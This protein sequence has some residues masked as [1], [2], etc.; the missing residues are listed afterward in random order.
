MRMGYAVNFQWNQKSLST[1]DY[2]L[3]QTLQTLWIL[4]GQSSLEFKGRSNRSSITWFLFFSLG[5]K[6]LPLCVIEFIF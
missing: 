4:E 3:Q 6:N 5:P 2:L 1:I